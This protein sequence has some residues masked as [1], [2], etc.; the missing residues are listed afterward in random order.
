MSSVVS[1]ISR[2]LELDDLI[3]SAQKNITGFGNSFLDDA[4]LGIMPNDLCLIGAKSGLG[5]SQLAISIAAY[6]ASACKKNVVFIALEA[7]QNEVEMRLRYSIEA[8]LFFK[9][10]NRDRGI[11]VSYRKW[12]LGYLQQ[13]FKKYKEEAVSIFIQ[14]Y[15]TLH[16]VYRDK[17][18]GIK[19]LEYTLD[20]AKE[21]GDLYI[22]DHLHFFDLTGQQNEH[23]ELSGIMKKIRELN[24]FYSKPMIAIAHLRKSIEGLVPSLEDFMGSSDLGKIATVCIMLAKYPDGYDVKNQLQKTVLTIPKARTGGLGNLCG[25]LDYSITHQGYLPRYNLARTIK[26][27]EKIEYIKQEEFPDWSTN[28]KPISP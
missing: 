12:R 5:K 22:C 19:E 6:N 15:S 28:A 17:T 10:Q 13:A 23:Q 11:T 20:E 14:R 21:F 3:S 9:D 25:I 7:E 8:S 16:T 2:E 26:G 18:Y 27:N 24:L 1:S 4:L